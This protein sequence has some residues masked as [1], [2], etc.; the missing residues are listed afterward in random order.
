[1]AYQEIAES[2]EKSGKTHVANIQD[3]LKPY[4]FQYFLQRLNA[5]IISS[6]DAWGCWII[7]EHT[8]KKL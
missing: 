6:S 8:T 2:L 4:L 1:M 3:L 7:Q 5:A